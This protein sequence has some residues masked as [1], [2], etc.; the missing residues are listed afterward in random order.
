MN[1]RCTKASAHDELVLLL[2]WVAVCL[3]DQ[4]FPSFDGSLGYEVLRQRCGAAPE[5]GLFVLAAQHDQRLAEEK[6]LVVPSEVGV[7]R[8]ARSLFLDV[9]HEICD[10]R[11]HVIFTSGHRCHA[12]VS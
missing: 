2:P 4:F 10:V 9:G 8:C 11:F 7:C 6:V 12:L 3:V 5:T 1:Q